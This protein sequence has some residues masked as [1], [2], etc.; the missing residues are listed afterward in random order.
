[1][2]K[3]ATPDG[4]VVG[5]SNYCYAL[6]ESVFRLVLK[7]PEW[8]GGKNRFKQITYKLSNIYYKKMFC[9]DEF[10]ASLSAEETCIKSQ[11]ENNKYLPGWTPCQPFTLESLLDSELDEMLPK[12]I[13][14]CREE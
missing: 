8:K 12:G 1:M 7:N 5:Y 10:S 13:S 2:M 4:A 6:G 11:E 14:Q 3:V 9:C